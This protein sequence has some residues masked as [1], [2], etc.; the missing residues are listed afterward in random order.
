MNE[1]RQ[2]IIPIKAAWA[3]LLLVVVTVC[4]GADPW[5]LYFINDDM[6]HIPLAYDGTIGHNNS[7]RHINDLSLYIDSLWSKEQG[8][9]YHITDL[10]LHLANIFLAIPLLQRIATSL[11]HPL[12]K[13]VVILMA[14]LFGIYAFHSEA[15]FWIL[16][17]TASL[18][19]LFNLLSWLCFFRAFQHRIWLLPMSIFFALGIFTYES[20]W[21]YPFYLLFWWML[22]PKGSPIRKKA[23]MPLCVIGVLFLAYFPIRL[24]LTGAMLGTYEANDVQQ[25]NIIAMLGKTFRLFARSFLQPMQDTRLFMVCFGLV[26]AG[27]MGML[28]LLWKRKRIDK[29]LIFLTGSWLMS[30]VL[31]VSL[32]V[33]VTGYES[34]R[35]LYF[36]SFFLCAA[37]VHAG[38][39]LWTGRSYLLYAAAVLLFHTV[40][41]IKAAMV[42]RQLGQYS[43]QSFEV[44]RE[45]PKDK[46]IIIKDLPVYWNG[47][48]LFNYGF[49]SGV[50]WLLQRDSTEVT[51]LSRKDFQ[52]APIR[53]ERMKGGTTA[54]SILFY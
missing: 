46:H 38:S 10:L 27:L 36:P 17:R 29:M 45:V 26:M 11:G 32:G 31:Y 35:Y 44:M 51:I 19:L 6:I 20:L 50:R 54:D 2:D 8:Y 49:G 28:F 13:S 4:I 23:I 18:S 5:Q 15:I 30:Y 9:G 1:L 39:R 48:P 21:I 14:A 52:R 37:L 3:I 53:M 24:Q 43:K 40:F 34:E 41:F 12:Q 25:F 42:F 33:S 7:V 47:L 16:C 22:L